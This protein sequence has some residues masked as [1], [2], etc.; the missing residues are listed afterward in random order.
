M[1]GAGMLGASLVHGGDKLLW[2]GAG[3]RAYT[4]ERSPMGLPFLHPWADRWIGSGM[5]RTATTSVLDRVTRP[6]LLLDDHSLP[7]HG[8]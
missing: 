3:V 6:L 8:V 1:P 7:I 4:R 2:Q 5:T